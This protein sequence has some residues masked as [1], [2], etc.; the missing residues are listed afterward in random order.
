MHRRPGG[1]TTGLVTQISI[2][3][4]KP[5]RD[6]ADWL[7]DTE[8][9][10][11]LE[12]IEIKQ[13][14]IEEFSPN[15]TV[16]IKVEPDLIFD[17]MSV[18]DEDPETGKAKNETQDLQKESSETAATVIEVETSSESTRCAREDSGRS[19]KDVCKSCDSCGRKF[20]RPEHLNRHRLVH[21]REENHRCTECGKTFAYFASFKKHQSSH[22]GERL[23]SCSECGKSFR[24][25]STLCDHLLSH[26][27][28]QYTCTICGKAFIRRHHLEG[29]LLVHTGEKSHRCLTCGKAFSRRSHLTSHYLVHSGEKPHSCETCGKRFARRDNLNVHLLLHSEEKLHLCS[30]CGKTFSQP[31]HL[32]THLLR[33]T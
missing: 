4:E 30:V 16:E 18:E 24:Q 25:R 10:S 31:R 11:Y 32:K 22:T 14:P 23:F 28:R 5:D 26:G 29:H 12:N 1:S 8:E 6:E 15:N 7:S 9:P 17:D 21:S 2:V 20:T 3:M 13:E 19:K 27:E 33:H